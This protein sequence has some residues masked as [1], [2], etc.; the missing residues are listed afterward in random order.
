MIV[1]SNPQQQLPFSSSLLQFWQTDTHSAEAILHAGDKKYV[2]KAKYVPDKFVSLSIELKKCI[3]G[4]LEDRCRIALVIA[5]EGC[6]KGS[7]LRNLCVDPRDGQTILRT[8]LTCDFSAEAVD[9][10]ITYAISFFENYSF[11]L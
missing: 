1:S 11:N 7:S 4:P 2:V 3:Q 5:E 6:K 10:F 8:L 9:A